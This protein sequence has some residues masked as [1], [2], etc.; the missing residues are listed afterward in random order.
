MIPLTS[1]I[2]TGNAPVTLSSY[3]PTALLTTSPSSG[4]IDDKLGVSKLVNSA[5]SK[6]PSVSVASRSRQNSDNRTANNG[7]VIYAQPNLA[8][9]HPQ[10]LDMISKQSEKQ[11]NG[12]DACTYNLTAKTSGAPSQYAT[13][14][15]QD[16]GTQSND[17]NKDFH[18]DNSTRSYSNAIVNKLN[19]DKSTSTDNL[20]STRSNWSNRTNITSDLLF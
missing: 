2:Q 6:A 16:D 4:N 5:N 10:V 20:A 17:V 13:Q 9:N 8:K 15:Y 12:H 1:P 14:F 11:L 3:K 7:S 18:E 19:G